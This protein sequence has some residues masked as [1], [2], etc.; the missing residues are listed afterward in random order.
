M[1]PPSWYSAQS[2]LF[3]DGPHLCL[4]ERF[5]DAQSNTAIERWY[6]IEPETGEVTHHSASTQAYTQEEYRSLL[7]ESGFGEVIF[8]V[9]P[10][11]HTGGCGTDLTLVLS[12]KK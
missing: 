12:R 6:V 5:W 3:S 9:P 7:V 8:S 1:Q 10:G 11:W 4:Q 2:G